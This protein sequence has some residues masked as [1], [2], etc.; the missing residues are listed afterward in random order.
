[1]AEPIHDATHTLT[2]AKPIITPNETSKTITTINSAEENKKFSHTRQVSQVSK[3][4]TSYGK[5]MNIERH[6]T[7]SA[8]N[9]KHSGPEI[10]TALN[11]N[12][13]SD[14]PNTLNI[15]AKANML[16]MAS[17]L[18]A[19]VEDRDN[20]VNL[21]NVKATFTKLDSNGSMLGSFNAKQIEVG[22]ITFQTQPLLNS[23]KT[24]RGVFVT[25]QELNAIRDP[26]NFQLSGNAP[27]G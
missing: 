24:G 7:A 10:Y 21:D 4:V 8:D 9:G 22:D 27:A 12:N 20:T 23:N 6:L 14:T 13:K 5:R 17:H 25:N 18:N 19:S 11:L 2:V 15:Q 16:G 3:A 26:N 1:M